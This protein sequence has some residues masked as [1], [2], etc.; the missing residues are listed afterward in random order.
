MARIWQRGAARRQGRSVVS[1]WLMIGLFLLLVLLILNAG[2]FMT[3]RQVR[4]TIED[5]LG[6]RLLAIA[7]AT[8][9]GIRGD[10][11]SALV[12]DPTDMVGEQLKAI[13]ARIQFDTDL[14]EIYLFDK[15]YRQLL[16]DRLDYDP[17]YNNPA[18]ELHF[19]AATAALAG[20]AVTSDLYQVGPVYLKTAFA[21]ISDHEDRVIGAVGVEGGTGFFAGLWTLRRQVLIN[22]LAGMLAILALAILFVRLRRTEAVAERTLRETAALAAAGELAAILAHEIR[23]PLAIISARA[24]RVRSKI[25][26]GR[27]KE[28]VLEWFTAIPREVDRLNG[29]L[30]Q[31]LS[32]ARPIDLV[33]DSVEIGTALD[34]ALSFLRE[35]LK[36]KGIELIPPDQRWRETALAIAPAALHQ[37]LLNIMLNARDAMAGGGTLSLTIGEQ[38]NEIWIRIADTGCGMSKE[39][40]RRAFESFFTTKE[41]GSGLGLATVRSMIELYGGEI[42]LESEPNKGTAVTLYLPRTLPIGSGN[43]AAEEDS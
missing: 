12:D 14:G 32:Y 43:Q 24:E 28:E 6:Q 36:R 35:D 27:S 19:G 4:R 20:V 11:M 8:A 41:H 10:Q 38:K 23:N 16:S 31:Y 22:A 39:E 40:K 34:A 37:I 17:S 2:L 15:N 26:K 13:L 30:T 33:D 1:S 21:P 29:T 25:E 7:C 42:V 5:E 18:L 9:A 3:Y